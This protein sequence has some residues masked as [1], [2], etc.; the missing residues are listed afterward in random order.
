MIIETVWER[1]PPNAATRKDRALK[2]AKAEK[3]AQQPPSQYGSP[4]LQQLILEKLTQPQPK[5]A[6]SGFFLGSTKGTP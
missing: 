6:D 4:E 3:L 2:A 1:R 5:P